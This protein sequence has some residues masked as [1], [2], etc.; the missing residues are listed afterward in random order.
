MTNELVRTHT[1][2]DLE[3]ALGLLLEAAEQNNAEDPSLQQAV[4]EYLEAALEKR[5]RVA[6]FIAHLEQQQELATA[7]IR[8]LRERESFFA[9]QQERL[10]GYVIHFLETKGIR[11]LE[12]RTVTV[13][14]RACPPSVQILDQAAIPPKYLVCKQEFV[15]DKKAL[16]AAIESG[17]EVPGVD[18]QVGKNSLLRR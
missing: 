16:K 3:E 4:D 12:G 18:L 13:S 1:L 9:R 2:Y 15:A 7:E 8:R 6:N 14:L 17:V 5:D 10:E 11:K